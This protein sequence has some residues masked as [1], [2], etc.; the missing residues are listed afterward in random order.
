[1]TWNQ[2]LTMMINLLYLSLSL[3]G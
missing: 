2:N 1:M 3:H